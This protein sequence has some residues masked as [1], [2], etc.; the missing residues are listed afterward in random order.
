[1]WHQRWLLHMLR[2]RQ[3]AARV[4]GEQQAWPLLANS[5]MPCLPA[6]PLV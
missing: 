6:C 5:L 4:R 1:M 2:R 3:A